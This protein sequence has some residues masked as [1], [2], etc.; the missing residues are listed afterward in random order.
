M[1]ALVAFARL[2]LPKKAQTLWEKGNY[3]LSRRAGPYLFT[4]YALE[5]FYIEVCYQEEEQV[6]T[7]IKVID[8]FIRL[9]SYMRVISPKGLAA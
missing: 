2:P 1:N 6:L 9:D 3:L 4:L 5:N 7:Q 8:S